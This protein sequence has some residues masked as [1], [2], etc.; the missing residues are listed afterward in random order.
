MKKSQK[1]KKIHSKSVTNI[2]SI[3]IGLVLLLA[4]VLVI[5]VGYVLIKKYGIPK[6]SQVSKSLTH[7]S[8]ISITKNGIFTPNS[9][10]VKKQSIVIIRN[11][12]TVPHEI[13]SNYPRFKPI[14][15]TANSEYSFAAITPGKWLL[16]FKNAMN[17]RTIVEIKAQ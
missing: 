7:E 14:T 11:D 12:D 4:G 3:L 10:S 13:I 2:N 17:I 5:M 15:I 9:L 6:K 8:K 1:R 16:L